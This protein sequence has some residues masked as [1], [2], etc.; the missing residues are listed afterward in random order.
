MSVGIA[1][2]KIGLIPAILCVTVSMMK[3]RSMPPEDKDHVDRRDFMTG[4]I[5]AV[6]A[7]AI[8]SNA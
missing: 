6:G 5:A 4:S 7:S 3:G 1:R 2:P 8:V